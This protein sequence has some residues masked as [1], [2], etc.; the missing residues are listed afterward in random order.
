[1]VMESNYQVEILNQTDHINSSFDLF[2]GDVV[3]DKVTSLVNRLI[4]NPNSP[5]YL[6]YG[7]NMRAHIYHAHRKELRYMKSCYCYGA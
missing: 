3:T 6:H 7:D 2:A 5:Y 1:M 4:S